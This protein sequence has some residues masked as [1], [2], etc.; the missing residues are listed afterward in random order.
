MRFTKNKRKIVLILF[1]VSCTL[2]ILELL[3]AKFS[4]RLDGLSR[5]Q[6]SLLFLPPL[7][8]SA[9]AFLL[10]FDKGGKVIKNRFANLILGFFSFSTT[11]LLIVLYIYFVLM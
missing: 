9:S 11:L 5:W 3:G 10:A 1:G 8:G 7:V 6:L 4:I 2:F